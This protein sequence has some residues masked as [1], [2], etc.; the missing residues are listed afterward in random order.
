MPASSIHAQHNR[1]SHRGRF[2]RGF[3][4]IELLVVIA[5]ITVL[6]AIIL[7]TIDKQRELTRRVMCGSN[8]RQIFE[9][10]IAY[11]S[12][13]HRMLPPGSAPYEG[14]VQSNIFRYRNRW[15]LREE[16][17]HYVPDWS[18]W[19]C[20]ATEAAPLDDPRNTRWACYFNY[21][22]FV[23]RKWPTMDGKRSPVRLSQSHA[24]ASRTM[25]QDN[26][27][28][29]YNANRVNYYRFNFNHGEGASGEWFN[30]SA[31]VNP[32]NF[33]KTSYQPELDKYAFGANLLMYDGHVEWVNYK[34]ADDL[35][36]FN[37][38]RR[39]RDFGR[40]PR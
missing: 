23:G 11:A 12:D 15:D 7:P 30:N 17:G 38:T 3:T 31:K 26:L 25:L 9:S 5:I 4:V 28:D 32:S 34:E 8:M 24:D 21:R 40:M 13:S 6:I 33:T 27:I 1:P 2:T 20:P 37:G 35:G 18:V 10:C 22:Y 14:G 39:G 36:W 19:V 29:W 16:V